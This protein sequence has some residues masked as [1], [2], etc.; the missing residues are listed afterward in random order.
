MKKLLMIMMVLICIAVL[1]LAAV[2]SCASIPKTLD[3]SFAVTELTAT[4]DLEA[5]NKGYGIYEPVETIAVGSIFYLY[6]EYINVTIIN[7]K[8]YIQANLK[9]TDGKDN[10]VYD[11]NVWDYE[12]PVKPGFGITDMYGVVRVVANCEPGKYTFTLIMTDAYGNT[13][14][15]A[16][17]DIVVVAATYTKS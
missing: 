3:D 2:V 10:V 5:M 9:L 6:W 12:G 13:T 11:I 16:S 14:S 1:S 17:C 7:E 8:A 4:T 15:T